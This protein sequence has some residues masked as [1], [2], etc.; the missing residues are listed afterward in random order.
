MKRLISAFLFSML[1]FA[2]SAQS[3]EDVCAK[4]EVSR[5]RV[6]YSF[7]IR[8]VHCSG[9]ITVQVPCFKASGNGVDVYSDGKTR[10]TVDPESREVYIEDAQ[11][12]DDYLKYL[13]DIDDL[14]LTG[15]RTSPLSDDLS[16]FVFDVSALDGS[17][18]V[19]DLR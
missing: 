16:P 5:V 9:T 4:L 15:L 19:T 6:D 12:P 8:K 10:W 18:V 17:W 13:N 2:A 1:C 3:I 11:G 14:S 7:S